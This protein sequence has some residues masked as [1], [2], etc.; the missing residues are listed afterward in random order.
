VQPLSIVL[1]YKLD[2]QPINE[3]HRGALLKS[4]LQIID[5]QTFLR[6]KPSLAQP[7]D[8]VYDPSTI[9][10]SDHAVEG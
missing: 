9:A 2:L 10:S 1:K 5:H 4:A 3:V 7:A 6:I 8:L